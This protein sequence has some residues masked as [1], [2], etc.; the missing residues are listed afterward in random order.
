MATQTARGKRSTVR[1]LRPARF[2]TDTRRRGSVMSS[3]AEP[4][5]VA[6]RVGSR[7][8]PCGMSVGVVGLGSAFRL[9]SFRVWLHDT[10]NDIVTVAEA[11]AGT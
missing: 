6:M 7:R 4:P 2:T 10:R 11:G 1:R 8:L 9:S 3:C 5:A